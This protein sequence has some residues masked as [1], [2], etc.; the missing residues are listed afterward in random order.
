MSPTAWMRQ[1]AG[2]FATRNDAEAACVQATG[3]KRKSAVKAFRVA[4]DTPEGPGGKSCP[5]PIL[6]VAPAGVAPRGVSLSDFL[7]RF[8]YA[9]ALRKAIKS[10]CR[11]KFVPDSDIR[12]ASGIPV[13][14]FRRVAEQPEF[15]ENQLRDGERLWWSSGENVKKVK[16]KQQYWGVTR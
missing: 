16:A 9:S 1:N 15:E 10:L 8:D 2:K 4:R 14:V 6:P 12:A 11:D 13:A 5:A 7:G 3:C